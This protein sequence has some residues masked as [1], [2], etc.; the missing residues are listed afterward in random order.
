MIVRRPPQHQP[1]PGL[2]SSENDFVHGFFFDDFPFLNDPFTILFA[3]HW[4][5]AWIAQVVIE[6]VAD[7]IKKEQM[8]Q[9]RIRLV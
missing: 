6:I 7:E 4:R 5:V 9:E 2:G 8:W 1:I 3:D